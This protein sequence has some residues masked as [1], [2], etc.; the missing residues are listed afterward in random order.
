MR[1]WQIGLA[2]AT[3]AL[4]LANPVKAANGP[5]LVPYYSQGGWVLLILGVAAGAVMTRRRRAAK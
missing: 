5:A 4:I 3:G 2:T 1:A